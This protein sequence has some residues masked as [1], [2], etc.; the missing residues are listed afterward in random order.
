MFWGSPLYDIH[1]YFNPLSLSHYEAFYWSVGARGTPLYNFLGAKYIIADGPP[2]DANFIPA[3]VSTDGPTIY[4]NLGALPLVHLVYEAITVTSM[5]NGW[6]QVHR[7]EWDPTSLVYVE[8]GPAMQAERPPDA[9][10]SIETYDPNRLVYTVNTSAPAYL[11]LSEVD[12]PGWRATIDGKPVPIYRANLAFRAILIE[13]PGEHTV[14][15]MFR[16]MAV[17]V[18]LVISGAAWAGVLAVCYLT[19][20]RSGAEPLI[21]A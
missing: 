17:Y 14:R 3:Y 15:V 9:R 4:L 19:S 20:R 16:P 1:G 6:N 5:E 8:N 11:V 18:G 21:E 12:Y 7:N 10:V 13:E 2:G